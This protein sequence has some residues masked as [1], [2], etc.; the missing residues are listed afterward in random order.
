MTTAAMAFIS[1]LWLT[2]GCEEEPVAR[3]ADF[4]GRRGMSKE[5]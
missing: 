4:W 1:Q 5:L 3:L 2:V